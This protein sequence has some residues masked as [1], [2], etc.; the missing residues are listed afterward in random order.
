M[1][2]LNGKHEILYNSAMKTKKP[3]TYIET[4]TGIITSV[5][6]RVATSTGKPMTIAVM[7]VQSEKRSSYPLRVIGFDME[8]L[9]LLTISR[10]SV[11]TIRGSYTWNSG[12]QLV[13]RDI[14]QN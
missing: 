1:A 7:Q 5:P 10:N 3:K 2:T 8:A 12:Y 9:E 11:I 4:V 13:V 6:R 14:K